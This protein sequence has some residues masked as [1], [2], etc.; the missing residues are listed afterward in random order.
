MTGSVFHYLVQSDRDMRL[1]IERQ[2]RSSRDTTLARRMWLS[3]QYLRLRLLAQR[4]AV[5]SGSYVPADG[6]GMIL[7]LTLDAGDCFFDVGANVGWVTQHGS[8][9]V[10]KQGSVHSF[11]PSPR[12][13]G[14]LHR[15]LVCMGLSNVVVNQ[16]ALGAAFGTATLYECAENY[17][18]SSSLRP[19]AAPGQ[20]I[21][22]ETRVPVKVLD[23]YVERNAITKVDLIKIDVQGSEIDVLRGA[24]H[25]LTAPNRPVLFVEVEQVAN[26]AFGHSVNDL[27]K[28]LMD[29]GY[30]LF[31]WRE[32]ELV[33]VESEA[34]IPVNGHDDL[35]C[36]SSGYH[37]ALNGYLDRW[38][39]QR[40]FRIMPATL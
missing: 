33:R 36:I 37:D 10:G 8:W 19:G 23:D 5:R 3:S 30:N 16:F 35:I 9:L 17:G 13:I 1:S 6:L 31:S 22:V 7:T 14:Y 26:T 34:D 28:L 29:F 25:L 27:L 12:T 11:E 4:K 2:I 32:T 18:G 21:L 38:R 39:Q 20:H 15:R 24:T 40:K